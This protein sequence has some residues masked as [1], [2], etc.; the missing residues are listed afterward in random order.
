MF[1]CELYAT[2]SIIAMESPLP[3]V[4][5]TKAVVW[6]AWVEANRPGIDITLYLYSSTFDNN[7]IALL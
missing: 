2:K 4:L 6:V 3:I 1:T 7:A 5:F